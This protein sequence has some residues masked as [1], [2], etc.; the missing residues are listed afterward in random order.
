MPDHETS[1]TPEEKDF[2]NEVLRQRILESGSDEE[3]DELVD[4]FAQHGIGRE[5]VEKFRHYAIQRKSAHETAHQEAEKRLAL[6][7]KPT[8]EELSMGS[9]IEWIEPQVRDAVLELRRKG[10]NTYESGFWGDEQKISFRGEPLKG[11]AFPDDFMKNMEDQGVSIIVKPTSII[12]SLKGK[13][14]LDEVKKIWD[15]IV[16]V[17]P[18]L[19]KPADLADVETAKIFRKKF[20]R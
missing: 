8:D 17:L 14:E 18:D 9:Y 3:M 12:F 6:N 15:K 20:G 10:Y 2:H 16:D 1:Y 5:E 4:F 7:P 13:L 19:G 11:Y